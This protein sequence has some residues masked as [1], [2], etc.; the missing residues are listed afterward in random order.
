MTT[1]NSKPSTLQ[2]ILIIL[3]WIFSAIFF[4]AT[5]G[6]LIDKTFLSA[7]IF[8][9][10]ALLLLP[11]FTQFWRLKIPFF[12][13]KL[14]KGGLLVSLFI[15]GTITNPNLSRDS[16]KTTQ[17]GSVEEMEFDDKKDLLIDYVKKNKA[18][19]KS[20]Q[21]ISKLGEIG[22]LFNNGNYSIKYPQDGYITEQTDNSNK[23][24]ILVFNPKFNFDEASVYLK[25]GAKNGILKDYIINFE[26]D[27]AGKI[28]SEKTII[29]Y[30][31]TGKIEYQ[32]NEVPSIDS[33]INEKVINSQKELNGIEQKALDQIAEHK[34]QMDQFEKNCLSGWDGS[35]GELVKYVKD[36]MDDPRSFEHIET[37]F[38]INENYV[39]IVMTYKGKNGYKGT[40]TKSIRAKVNLNDC[41][42]VSVEQ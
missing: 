2:V 36:R 8:L 13:N 38:G 35:H 11:S 1:T 33:F 19:D 41:S 18:I 27:N 17:N 3:K 37:R 22:E 7:L 20:L 30:S 40:V 5:L 12:K 15:I 21:N 25:N 34:K 23:K 24:K 31:K 42:L 16:S 4:L 6:S 9:L 26:L 10:I 32:K 39:G 14:I 29:T 28:I